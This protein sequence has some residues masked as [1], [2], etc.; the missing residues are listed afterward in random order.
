MLPESFRTSSRVPSREMDIAAA[1]GLTGCSRRKPFPATVLREIRFMRKCDLTGCICALRVSAHE[2]RG[3]RVRLARIV[4]RAFRAL[5]RTRRS[6]RTEN[7]VNA[8]PNFGGSEPAC[9]FFGWA[10]QSRVLRRRSKPLSL[11]ASRKTHLAAVSQVGPLR[12][13]AKFRQGPGPSTRSDRDPGIGRRADRKQ[14][15]A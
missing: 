6:R 14:S 1:R 12:L 4:P 15:V 9:K 11:T 8:P 3:N 2:H 7:P 10:I 5:R 13:A